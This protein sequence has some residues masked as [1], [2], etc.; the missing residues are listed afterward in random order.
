LEEEKIIIPNMTLSVGITWVDGRAFFKPDTKWSKAYYGICHFSKEV[1][2]MTP[3]DFIKPTLL[4]TIAISE[5]GSYCERADCCL[6]FTCRL[7]RFTVEG[8][9]KIFKDCGAF[10][11]G[12]PRNI[13][14]KTPLWFN[15]GKYKG[16]WEKL[17]IVPDGGALKYDPSK[18]K[19]DGYFD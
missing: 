16:F 15:V 19:I 7:N 12:L 13:R 8:F 4:N 17:M 6:N 11:L 5:D 9:Q 18:V 3:I 1:F 2:L 10:S 14:E